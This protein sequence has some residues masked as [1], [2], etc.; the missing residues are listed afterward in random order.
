M[1]AGIADAANSDSGSSAR[2]SVTLIAPANAG[3]GWDGAAR[4]AQQTLRSEGIV[5]S[6]TV[7]N[8]PGAGGTIGLSQLAQ[9]NGESTTLMVMGITMLGAININGSGV[10]L[11]DVT[12]IA[13]LSDD[14]DV[15]VV[16][17]DSPY[18]TVDDLVADWEQDPTTFPIGGGSLGSLDQMIVA[19]VAGEAG[20]DPASVNYMA[21]SGGAELATAL[22]SGTI[23]ASVSGMADFQD[24][25][26]AGRLKVLAVSAEE[27]VP[28]IDAPTLIEKG[29]DV[30][31]TN[32]RGIVAP[33]GLEPEEV[34]ELQ[35]IVSEMIESET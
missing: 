34:T 5:N 2:A 19:Q 18:D 16:P 31:L 15:L 33:P 30:S 21:H 9:M 14:Y 26:E 32:W 22:L 20:M 4:E 27:P 13:R 24:Q 12:P 10:S 17:A 1:A 25:V 28:G 8:I 6:P 3:G 23:S 35:A 11:D 7:V 29:Y